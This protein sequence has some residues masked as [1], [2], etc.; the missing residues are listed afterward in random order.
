[1]HERILTIGNWKIENRLRKI[2]NSQLLVDR[3][4]IVNS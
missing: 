3:R 1:M 4:R 2:V